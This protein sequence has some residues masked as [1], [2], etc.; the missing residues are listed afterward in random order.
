MPPEAS[1]AEHE[2]Y[3]HALGLDRPLHIQYFHFVRDAVRGD[4]GKSYRFGV[5]VFQLVMEKFPPTVELAVVGML[6]A[7]ILGFSSGIISATRP[8]TLIDKMV[9]GL[10]LMGMAAPTFWVGIMLILIFSVQFRLFPISGRGGLKSLIL[11]GITLGWYSAAVISRMMRSTML[12]ILDCDYIRMAILKGAP[13]H[14]VI[15]KHA[16]RNALTTMITIV[17]LQFVILLAGAVITETI[18]A[19]PGIG[20]LLIQSVYAGDYPV[21][22]GITLICSI[23]FVLINLAVDVLYVVIDPRIRYS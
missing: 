12:D 20:R 2:D 15:F 1:R 18:F 13:K 7:V 22:Q 10:S 6:F 11:P 14:V 23:L 5:P 21:I 17:S 19:W 8:H 4:F 3:R 9:K 16:L